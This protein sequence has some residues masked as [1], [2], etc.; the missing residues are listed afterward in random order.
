MPG[1]HRLL[2]LHRTPRLRRWLHAARSERGV[3]TVIFALVLPAIIGMQALVL[4]GTRVFVERRAL[5]NA[6]D[7][8][9]LAAASY[10]PST[11]PVVLANAAQAAIDYA[12]LNG[13]AISPA[14]ITFVSDAVVN[15][16]VTVRTRGE[17]EFVFATGLGLNLGA[18]SSRGSAQIGSVGG[19]GGTMPWGVEEPPGGFIFGEEYCLKLGSGGGGGQCS[20]AREGNFH[21]LDIDETGN[22]SADYY[23]DLIRFGSAT[24]I[25]IGQ[26]KPVNTG[27]MQGPTQQGTGC[28]GNNGRMT[29][30]G[31]TFSQVVEAT[32]DG[33]RILD[34]TNS[35]LIFIPVVT[36]PQSHTALVIGFTVFFLEDCGPNGS[37]TGRFI[38]TVVPGGEW[39]AFQPGTGSRI[40]RIVE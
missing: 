34:W 16:R 11:D 6:A 21:A 37:V 30:N 38:D 5:Q 14:D 18:V 24:V 35:R 15:D 10:L 31:A 25:R 33:Y 40:V 1:L 22:S 36:F 4:D 13:Y 8:A 39:M 7:A 2:S 28:S 20:G 12:A 19:L 27:N 29:G 17:V 3:S 26:L 23:R 9:A 32:A